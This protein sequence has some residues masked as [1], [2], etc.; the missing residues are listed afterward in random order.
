MHFLSL[1]RNGKM[2][3]RVLKWLSLLSKE[4]NTMKT[5]RMGLEAISPHSF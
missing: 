3:D 4:Q 1:E 5:Q 2:E